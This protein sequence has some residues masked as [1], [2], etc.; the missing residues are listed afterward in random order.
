MTLT[1]WM[2]L[3]LACLA[4]ASSPGPSLAL[5]LQTIM[6]D[7]R[8]AGVVF[9]LAHGLGI[10]FYAVLVVS[11]VSVA[12]SFVPLLIDFVEICGLFFLMWLAFLMFKSSFGTEKFDK[13]EDIKYSKSNIWHARSGF[14][15]VFLNPKV[16]A[17]FLAIFTQFLGSSPTFETKSIMV[18]TATVIDAGWYVL[19]SFIMAMPLFMKFLVS[20]SQ[21]LEFILGSILS[22][23]SILLGFKILTNLLG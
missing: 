6:K 11:G 19:M 15:V 7:G 14:L 20:N 2:I 13:Q 3:A 21:R 18:L 23:V 5:L 8:R 10:F 4:G 22:I 17:F 9:G 16:A 1:E 12:L